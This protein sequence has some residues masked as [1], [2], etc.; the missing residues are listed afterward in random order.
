MKTPPP[1][2]MP[3]QSAGP[4]GDGSLVTMHDVAQ[5][6]GLSRATVSKYFNADDGL[7]ASTRARIEKACR[8]LG[9]VPQMHAVS[10]VKGKSHL[11]GVIVPAIG[12]PFFAMM[13]EVLEREAA[14]VGLQLI[15]QSSNNNPAREAAAL[16]AFRAMKLH[17]V[18]VT[19]LDAEQNRPLLDKLEQEMRIVHLDSY[20]HPN[21]HYV[22]NDN[23]QSIGLMT[24]YFLSR[25]RRPCYLG[26]PKIANP[27]R[28]ERLAGYVQAMERAGETPRVIPVDTQASTWAFEAYAYEQTLNW[29]G[30]GEWL[31]AEIDGVICATDRLALGVM[32]A[33]RKIG[34]EPGRDIWISGHD[35]LGFAE[36]IQPGLTTLRQD[37]DSIGRAAIECLQLPD[38]HF[39]ADRP[40]FQQRFPGRLVLRESA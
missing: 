35:D 38:E 34:K 30:S 25:G 14:R 22:M 2:P 13:L 37:I 33:F 39:S 10:L 5:A 17:G 26:A 31:K 32:R 20:L 40:Y 11:V 19:V 23:V 18:I 28:D 27:S 3:E 21:C 7:K 15:I 9:Y 36:Y 29:L 16:L 24:E 8:E 1:P 6:A 4:A 12:E